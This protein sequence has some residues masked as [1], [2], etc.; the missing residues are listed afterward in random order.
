MAEYRDIEPLRKQIVE[1][2]TVIESSTKSGFLKDYIS[3]VDAVMEAIDKLPTA[4]VQEVVR[5]KDCKFNDNCSAQYYA[6][7]KDIDYCSRGIKM[8]GE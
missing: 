3:G 5:C 1:F 7:F 2:K 6:M 8:D 4:D